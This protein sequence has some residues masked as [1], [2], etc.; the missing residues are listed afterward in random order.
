MA[1]ETYEGRGWR[2]GVLLLTISLLQTVV[3]VERKRTTDEGQ[4]PRSGDLSLRSRCIRARY[5]KYLNR[6]TGDWL[7]GIL[8]VAYGVGAIQGML[9][10]SR[11]LWRETL[12]CCGINFCRPLA[13]CCCLSF[14]WFHF[15]SLF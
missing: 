3:M 4:A 11:T 14:L 1:C 5:H 6:H 7:I 13:S 9:T 2:C 8:R 10:G 12:F 15:L